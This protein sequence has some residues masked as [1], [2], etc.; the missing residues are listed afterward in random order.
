MAKKKKWKKSKVNLPADHAWE[1]APGNK[2]FV[3]DAGAMQ[4]EVPQNWSIKQGEGGSI[5]FFDRK[6]EKDADMRLEVSLIYAPNIDWSGLPL[7]KLV[8]DSVLAGDSRGLTGRSPFNHFFR[9]S[10]EGV[11]LE[12]DFVDEAEDLPAHS[13]LQAEFGTHPVPARLVEGSSGIPEQVHVVL[14]GTSPAHLNGRGI[15]RAE[16]QR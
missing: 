8:E 13:P 4:F 15:A 6:K 5:R 12:V 10:L 7:T 3:A 14:E 16:A 9:G 11:W 2:V 1:A